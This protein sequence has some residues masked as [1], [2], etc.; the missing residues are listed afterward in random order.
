MLEHLI[1]NPTLA[2]VVHIDDRSY[3]PKKMNEP[4][5]PPIVSHY[6]AIHVLGDT[7]MHVFL[8]VPLDDEGEHLLTTEHTW[9]RR[10]YE[11]AP[12]GVMPL[13][14]V[15]VTK[16]AQPL[17]CVATEL[18]EFDLRRHPDD[19]YDEKLAHLL[20]A[21]Y[22]LM[23][24]HKNSIVHRDVKPENILITPHG[25]RWTDFGSSCEVGE[26]GPPRMHTPGF[27]AP[28]CADAF[29][30]RETRGYTN[31]RAHPA[32][33]VYAFAETV[34]QTLGFR[35]SSP[36]VMPGLKEAVLSNL[37]APAKDRCLAYLLT[38]LKMLAPRQKTMHAAG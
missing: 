16:G 21:G 1:R 2:N 27:L 5:V 33:D 36:G 20:H 29:A 3:H 35:Y 6:Q 15:T 31:Y 9:H 22:A 10:A 30:E 8:K 12:H 37:H 26:I 18:A 13:Q 24:M 34:S 14:D 38:E 25:A 7:P 19:L 28:E 32:E 17:S 4:A 23:L 11:A